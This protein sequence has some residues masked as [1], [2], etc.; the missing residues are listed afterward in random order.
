MAP[1]PLVAKQRTDGARPCEL[2]LRGCVGNATLRTQ[3]L[4]WAHAN[5]YAVTGGCVEW[6]RTETP[7]AACDQMESDIICPVIKVTD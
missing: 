2:R 3:L 1:G 7:G 6:L 5:G 4:K